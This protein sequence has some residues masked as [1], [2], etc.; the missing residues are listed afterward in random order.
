M[1][2]YYAWKWYKSLQN[3]DVKKIKEDELKKI[4]RDID[5]KFNERMRQFDKASY[6][7]LDQYTYSPA[8]ERLYDAI[9]GYEGL[10][11][12]NKGQMQHKLLAFMQFSN[13][14]TSTVVGARKWAREQDKRIFGVTKDSKGRFQAKRRMTMEE[15][16]RFWA[17]YNSYKAARPQDFER[18][19]S[20]TVQQIISIAIYDE[21]ANMEYHEI[22][23]EKFNESINRIYKELKSETEGIN[24]GKFGN[25]YSGRGDDYE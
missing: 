7:K 14:A 24:R 11:E 3:A 9:E 1:A 10:D 22:D 15:R 12:L 19:T 21:Y 23:Y 17:V 20:S 25:V 5:K 16:Q 13:A 8:M 18:L 6:G 2:Q 4:M